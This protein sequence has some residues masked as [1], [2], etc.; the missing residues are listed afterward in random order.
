MNKLILTVLILGFSL[1]VLGQEKNEEK[2]P[3]DVKLDKCLENDSNYTSL[4]M[5]RCSEIAREDWDKELNK[6]Y[7]LLMNVLEEDA[8]AK[9]KKS[10]IKW[11]EF[12]DLEYEFSSEMYSDMQGTM[13]KIVAAGRRCEIVKAR[14]LALKDYYETYIFDER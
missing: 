13:W 2:N 1:S 3:I 10:Q 8:K 11:I 6:Y 12:R 5:I 4:G 14:A 9:L 7:K